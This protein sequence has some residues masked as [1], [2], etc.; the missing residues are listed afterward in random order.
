MPRLSAEQLRNCARERIAD[1]RLPVAHPRAMNAGYGSGAICCVCDRAIE[2]HEV[3]YEV[4]DPRGGR[5][6]NFHL[7]CHTS[8]QL[9]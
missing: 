8:W 5:P 6:L 3:E 4:S 1:G 2:A 9:E 7:T